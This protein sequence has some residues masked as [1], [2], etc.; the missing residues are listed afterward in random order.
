MDNPYFASR[1]SCLKIVTTS[2]LLTTWWK[3]LWR[4]IIILL[5]RSYIVVTMLLQRLD[6]YRHGG[7]LGGEYVEHLL[8]PALEA[9]TTLS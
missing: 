5:P 1:F 2:R 7:Y 8:G 9:V 3:F 4:V 6:V